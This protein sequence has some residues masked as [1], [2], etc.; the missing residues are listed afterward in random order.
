MPRTPP[1]CGYPILSVEPHPATLSPHITSAVE[2]TPQARPELHGQIDSSPMGE[3]RLCCPSVKLPESVPVTNG[4][5]L[6]T[7]PVR[8]SEIQ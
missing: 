3:R 4:T 7:R 1:P 2:S 6:G 5:C 8:T